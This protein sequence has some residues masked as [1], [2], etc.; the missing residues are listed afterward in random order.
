MVLMRIL[1][2]GFDWGS[3]KDDSVVVDIGGGIG[4][5]SVALAKKYPHLKL[6]VQDRGPVIGDGLEVRALILIPN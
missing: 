4:T 2:L 3:L 5:L 6:V 1:V